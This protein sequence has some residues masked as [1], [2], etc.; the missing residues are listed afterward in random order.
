MSA[1]SMTLF[2][3]PASPVVRAGRLVLLDRAQAGVHARDLMPALVGRRRLG[4]AGGQDVGPGVGLGANGRLALP[5]HFF[6]P[7]DLPPGAA[8][9]ALA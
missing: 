6:F 3:H 9:S 5:L 1:P 7:F 2:Q 4:R 8:S